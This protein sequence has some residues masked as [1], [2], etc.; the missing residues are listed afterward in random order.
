MNSVSASQFLVRNLEEV[1]L[2]SSIFCGGAAPCWLAW[3][4]SPLANFWWRLERSEIRFVG[5][6]QAT[7]NEVSSNVLDRIHEARSAYRWK[8]VQFMPAAL[9]EF[10]VLEFVALVARK[11]SEF[12]LDP[13][14]GVQKG[15]QVNKIPFQLL[16]REARQNNW[17]W[18]FGRIHLDHRWYFFAERIM[19]P[20]ITF[21][22]LG[23]PAGA[24][25]PLNCIAFER[26]DLSIVSLKSWKKVKRGQE[27]IEGGRRM[28]EWARLARL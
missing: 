22:N 21:W 16:F 4:L 5:F 20:S 28:S 27:A 8:T 2:A 23:Y 7:R 1:K 10:Q 13:F 15:L 6:L 19:M 17:M 24:W 12:E 3:L 26:D 18:K 9:P 14:C 11:M 25:W